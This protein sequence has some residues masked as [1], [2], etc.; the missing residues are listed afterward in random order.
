VKDSEN[1][2]LPNFERGQIVGACLVGASVT[3]TATLLVASRTTVSKVM[4]AYTHLRKTTSAKRNSGQNSTL[5]ERDHSTLRSTVPKNQRT[6]AAQ[7]TQ[8]H[9]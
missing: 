8:Q 3:E 9:N 1:G 7:V 5:T 2:R 6:T 4:S